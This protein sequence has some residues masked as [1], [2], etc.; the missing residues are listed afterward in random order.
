MEIISMGLWEFAVETLLGSAT[1][2]KLN[3]KFENQGFRGAKKWLMASLG[4]ATIISAAKGI[5]DMATRNSEIDPSKPFEVKIPRLTNMREGWIKFDD[6]DDFDNWANNLSEEDG[7]EL[8]LHLALQDELN[9]SSNPLMWK[10]YI[11]QA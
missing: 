2:D 7:T 5:Y 1:E 6:Q 4:A 10:K 11:R 8:F 9:N 3:E